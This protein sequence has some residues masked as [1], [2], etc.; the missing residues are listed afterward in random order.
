MDII[1]IAGKGVKIKMVD[2]Y[3]TKVE[4][5]K[6]FDKYEVDLEDRIL[7]LAELTSE[8]TVSLSLREMTKIM[9]TS[10]DQLSVKDAQRG[11][12]NFDGPAEE[13]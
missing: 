2:L 10:V 4:I 6:I 8:S 7:I 11:T 5:V 13:E 12:E 3:N 9:K 1:G